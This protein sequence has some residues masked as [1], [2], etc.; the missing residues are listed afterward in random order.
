[1][2]ELIA[3]TAIALSGCT[4]TGTLYNHPVKMYITPHRRNS[5]DIPKPLKT[6]SANAKGSKVPKSPTAPDHSD[7]PN[8]FLSLF[9]FN[10]RSEPLIRC[11][12]GWISLVIQNHLLP[13]FALP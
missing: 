4:E 3:I 5:R 7:K 9:V 10:P 12:L 13:G 11:N 1:M 8:L 6:T 2:P